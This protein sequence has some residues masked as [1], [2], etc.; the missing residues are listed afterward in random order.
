MDWIPIFFIGFSVCWYALRAH[1]L[2]TQES[3]SRLQR[4]LGCIFVWWGMSTLKDL[5]FYPP[6][7][8]WGN[9]LS[10]VFFVDGCGA[11]TFALLLLELTMPGWVT[12]RRTA[13]ML[14]PFLVF[15]V[16]HL[17]IHAVWLNIAFTVFFVTFAWAAMLIAVFKGRI[18][19]RAIRQNYSDLENVDISWMWYIMVAFFVCQHVWWFVSGTL[20]AAV[21][22]FYYVSS[23]VCWHFTLEGVNRLRP[24]R[25]PEAEEQPTADVFPAAASVPKKRIGNLAGRLE[26]LMEDER[27]YL[28]PDLTMADLTARLGT[29]RTYLSEYLST[30]LNTTFYDY[31]NRLRIERSVIPMMQTDCILSLE[32]IAAEAGFKSITTFRRAF[33]KQTGVLPSEYMRQ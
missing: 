5:L 8:D 30:E 33:R 13:F 1:E 27:L 14:L 15:F 9:V 20:D 22:S 23:L 19:A 17:F 24:L 12:R 28:N 6:H 29:N 4:L 3:P 2:F 11:V 18:Y 32:S 21:D 25:L 10:H 7:L 31:I 16:L 26:Q